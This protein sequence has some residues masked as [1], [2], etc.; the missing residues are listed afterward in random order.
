MRELGATRS[1]A[2]FGIAPFAGALLSIILFRETPQLLFWIAIPL[3]LA[4]TWLMLTEN[5]G[6]AH[7]H[8]LIEHTHRHFHAEEHH[9]HQ[10]TADTWL[11]KGW[12]SHPHRH[13]TLDHQHAHT[14]DL[15]HRH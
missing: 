7:T 8:E 15:H 4:G 3:M 6:H 1:S 13:T 2:L 5:H 12:H 10:H 14:P 9:D 11:V